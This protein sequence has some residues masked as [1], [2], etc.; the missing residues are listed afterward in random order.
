MLGDEAP[1]IVSGLGLVPSLWGPAVDGD[2][3][4]VSPF[5]RIAAGQHNAVPLIVGANA[6]E[7]AGW[8]LTPI[9]DEDYAPL[10][11][12]AIGSTF[13][14]AAAQDALE[15]YPLEDFDSARDAL[16]AITTD[17]QFVCPARQI[18][19]AAAENQ[20]EPVFRYLYDHA[21]SGLPFSLAR[22]AHGVELPFV[23]QAMDRLTTYDPVPDDL[24]VEALMLEHWGGFA[25]DGV[26][27]PA[28][29]AYD[30]A[31]DPTFTLSPEPAMGDGVRTARCD[32]W[33]GLT[34]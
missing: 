22:A 2:V 28:W 16:I 20:T 11:V 23:F 14:L 34:P 13:G 10:V 27:G 19:A 8:I 5:D 12:A 21:L 15:A 32:F 17:S 18:A 31:S 7:T 33:D 3:L 1:E 4:P 25:R 30:P 24:V 9:P 29:T 26:P 6:D